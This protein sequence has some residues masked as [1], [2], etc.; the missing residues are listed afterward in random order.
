MV[1]WVCERCKKTYNSMIGNICLK[2]FRELQK[3]STEES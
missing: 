1:D 3:R 2:C